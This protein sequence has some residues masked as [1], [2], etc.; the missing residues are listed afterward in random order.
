VV[1]P[2]LTDWL[3]LAGCLL[4]PGGLVLAILLWTGARRSRWR[5]HDD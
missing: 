3:V 1:I 5:H 2:D 4:G